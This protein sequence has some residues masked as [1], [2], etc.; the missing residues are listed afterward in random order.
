MDRGYVER[1]E[2]ETAVIGPVERFRLTEKGVLLAE[3][4]D[5]DP[6]VEIPEG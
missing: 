3:G 1:E 2:R 5:V 4:G 6:G